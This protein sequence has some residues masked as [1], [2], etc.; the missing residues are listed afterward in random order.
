MDQV[1]EMSRLPKTKI[2][3]YGSVLG[4]DTQKVDTRG[5]EEAPQGEDDVRLPANGLQTDGPGELVQQTTGRDGQV[6]KG[7]TLGTHL[8]REHFDGVQRLQRRD[9]ETEDDTEDVD[10]GEVGAGG[11]RVG[12]AGL[13]ED[14]GGD[15]DAD[16]GD[17]AAGHTGQ[18]E[19]ATAE[20]VG[21]GGADDGDDELHAHD[22]E[23]DVLLSDGVGDAGGVEN[24][25]QKVGDDG[26]AGPLAVDGDHDVD[27]DTVA[28]GAVAEQSA[29]V[30]PALVTAVELEMLFVLAELECHPWGFGVAV[31][32]VLDQEVSALLLLAVDVLPTGGLGH[33]PDEDGDQAG[34]HEL[35][36]DG[37]E[38]GGVTGDG[39]SPA[40]GTRCDDGADEPV[41]RI[42]I[43]L[44][45]CRKRRLTR[46][47]CTERCT[48]LSLIHI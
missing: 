14:G 17:G 34:E 19:E 5:L 20:L 10:E 26:V 28:R 3:T 4:L 18:E 48:H 31:A 15:G 33:E 24:G 42:S 47:C 38:P 27:A 45:R 32:V 43:W 7:H 1:S 30:P 8:E 12:V 2:D 13:G 21:E 22:A 41:Y 29:V 36:P 44:I 11:G 40:S 25:G 39:K 37:D 23:R 9:A 35:E 46:K 6:A 16:P